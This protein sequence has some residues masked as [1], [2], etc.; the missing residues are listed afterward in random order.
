VSLAPDK[1]TYKA[2]LAFTCALAGRYEE[3]EAGLAELQ[4]IADRANVS[5]VDFAFVQLGLGH[6][7]DALAAMERAVDQ[8]ASE[9]VY[10]MVDPDFEALR[11]LPRFEA[12]LKRIG[13]PTSPGGYSD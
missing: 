11:V 5:A 8:R 2:D 7:D 12:L 9:V 6:V 3:A 10:F 13:L 1:P 4:A